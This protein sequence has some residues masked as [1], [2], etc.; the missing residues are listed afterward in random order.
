MN[1]YHILRLMQKQHTPL[2]VCSGNKLYNLKEN[3]GHPPNC[4][5][6]TIVVPGAYI[7][8]SPTLLDDLLPDLV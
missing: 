8:V 3:S 2:R 5:N 1:V 7:L 6:L 4:I